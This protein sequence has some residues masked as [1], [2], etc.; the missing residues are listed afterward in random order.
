MGYQ[1]GNVCYD[2]KK[3]AD[4]AYYSQVSPILTENGVIQLQYKGSNWYYQNQ[5]ITAN[6]PQCSPSHNYQLGYE[7]GMQLLPLAVLLFVFKLIAR[8]IMPKF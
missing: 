7:M 3:L 8:L 2:D 5:V 1:V 6:L 4:N